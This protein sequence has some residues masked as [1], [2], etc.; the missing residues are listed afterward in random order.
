MFGAS[1]SFIAPPSLQMP[2]EIVEQVKEMGLPLKMTHEIHEVIS[3]VDVLYVTRIQ[4]ER[5]PDPQEYAKVA[6]TYRIDVPLLR[7]ARKNLIILHPLPRVNEIAPDVDS[8]PHARYF[9]QASNGVSV[10]MA[11]LSL[12]LGATR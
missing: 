7:D 11:L 6:G 5:F 1:M 10:R 8:T 3:D 4:K 2:R 12:I 9:Q